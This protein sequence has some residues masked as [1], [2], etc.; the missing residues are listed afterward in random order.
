MEKFAKFIVSHKKIILGIFSLVFIV[1]LVLMFNVGQN[2][3]M[4]KYLPKKSNSKQGIDILKEEYQ[5][6]GQAFVLLEDMSINEILI[7]EKKIEQVSGVD[8]VLWLDDIIDLAKPIEIYD[9]KLIENYYKEDKALLQIVFT[10]SDY[11][12][13]TREALEQIEI[14]IGSNGGLSGSAVDENNTVNS[15]GSNIIVGI[16]VAVLIIIAILIMFISS[17]FEV[18]L[19]LIT[20]G[21]SIVINM[22]TNIIFG[23]ISYMTFVSAAILQLAISMDYSI[24]LLHRF[25]EEK[26][27]T[28]NIREA[29]AKAIEGSMKAVFSSATTTIAGFLALIFMSYTIGMDMG[30]VLAKGILFSFISVMVLL[31]V[32]VLLSDKLI[33]KTTHRVFLP[34]FKGMQKKLGGKIKYELIILILIIAVVSFLGQRSNQFDFGSNTGDDAA[35]VQISQSITDTFG[36]PNIMILL[37]PNN[38]SISELELL[39][40]LDKINGIDS[41]MG[42]YTLIDSNIPEQ[43]IPIEVVDE[44]KSE[45]YSRYIIYTNTAIESENTFSIIEEI[46][47]T[48][49]IY[50]SESYLTGASP[51]IMDIRDVTTKDFPIVNLISIIA[52]G[53]IILLAFKSIGI[54][55]LLL[56]VIEASIWM[57]MS[58][59]YFSGT[60]I[61]FI[62][63]MIVSA[64]QLGATIDYAILMTNYYQEGRKILNPKEAAIYAV[65]KAGHSIFTSAIILAAAGFTIS[66]VFTQ[67]ELAQL[68]ILIGR[69]ALLSGGMVIIVLPQLLAILDKFIKKTTIKK[70][71]KK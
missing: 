13:E 24:F 45:N 71:V 18:V 56:L 25:Q 70:K 58:I 17:V 49:S 59:P 11:S 14:I 68:G 34:S 50:F 30:L 63:Y 60:S 55:F 26:K 27:K 22:G 7:Y 3:D 8:R 67:P 37:I 16:I 62:G 38:D 15:I 31:P 65:D 52:V 32:L 19:F 61:M 46:R 53:L 9:S 23:E 43:F 29:M 2:Y 33:V 66:F 20:I 1:C 44:F 48:T 36:N 47:E 42:Y 41:I 35:Q 12:L 39:T 10:N 5:Y 4:S 21:I 51:G 69:G 54:P 64:V 57:N 6:N 28:N 40:Q